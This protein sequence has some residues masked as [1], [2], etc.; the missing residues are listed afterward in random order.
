MRPT[1]RE[2]FPVRLMAVMAGLTAAAVWL[3]GFG[4]LAANLREY[5]WWTLAAGGTAWLAALALS[6]HG[7]RGVAA[8]IAVALTIGWSATALAV[9]V[10]WVRTGAWPLW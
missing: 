7:D 6:R 2:P 4:A 3:A 8:G 10:T 5:T 1:L 9:A